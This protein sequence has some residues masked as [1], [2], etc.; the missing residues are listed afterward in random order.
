MVWCTRLVSV[1]H[2]S[3]RHAR[4]D[5][6]L[7]GVRFTRSDVD[8]ARRRSGRIQDIDWESVA[9]ARVETTRK[10]RAVI[11]VLVLGAPEVEK[12][13]EDPHAVKVPRGHA[14]AAHEL[15]AYINDEV[16]VRRSWRE[17]AASPA[18]VA[19]TAP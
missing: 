17:Q 12:H 13:Q 15:V 11:R 4:I 10:G 14:E 9:G 2:L 3:G 18:A 8:A 6:S 7:D 1:T 19:P 16:A 5:V